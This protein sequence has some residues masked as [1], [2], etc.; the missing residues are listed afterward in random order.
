MHHLRGRVPAEAIREQIQHFGP[1]GKVGIDVRRDGGKAMFA[2][3][4]ADQ[5]QVVGVAISGGFWREGV[6]QVEV[7]VERRDGGQ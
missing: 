6:G 4:A 2:V 7:G 3:I 1:L 5:A